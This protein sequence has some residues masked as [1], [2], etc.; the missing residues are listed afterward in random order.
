MKGLDPR[1]CHRL[2]ITGRCDNKKCQY[3]HTYELTKSEISAIRSLA[4]EMLCPEHK[5]GK[6]ER[7]ARAVG[8]Y[9]RLTGDAQARRRL[10]RACMGTFAR[11]AG[12]HRERIISG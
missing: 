2:Y 4:K 3:G 11:A 8:G 5:V 1:P 9:E 10:S 6:C 12:K 7:R